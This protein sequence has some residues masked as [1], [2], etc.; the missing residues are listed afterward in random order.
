[1]NQLEVYIDSLPLEPLAFFFL[2]FFSPNQCSILGE[3]PSKSEN[4]EGV[5]EMLTICDSNI[6]VL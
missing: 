1:M 6:L 4:L 2:T 3:T 5:V